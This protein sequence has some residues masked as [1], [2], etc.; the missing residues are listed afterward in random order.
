VVLMQTPRPMRGM[1][2]MLPGEVEIRRRALDAIR[3]TYR[4]HGFLEI[5][6]PIVETLEALEASGAGENEKLMFKLLKR[7]ERLEAALEG[8]EGELAD[9]GLRFDLTVP[10]ARFYA[11]NQ[12]KLPKPFY[13]MQIGPVFRAERPQKGRYRQFIQTDIDVLG[14][15]S[16]MAEIQLLIAATAALHK[17]GIEGF[18]IHLNDRRV[19]EAV[20]ESL[21]VAR[22]L[23]VPVMIALDKLDKVQPKAVVDE[24]EERGLPGEHATR[25]V[26]TLAELGD[27]ESDLDLAKLGIDRALAAPLELIQRHVSESVR[28]VEVVFDPLTVRGLGYYTSTV[29]ELVHPR[30]PGSLGGGGRY[31]DLVGRFGV[32]S[33]A[34]GISLGFERV[35]GK[36]KK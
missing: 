34:C 36:R 26:A 23:F 7:G 6:T 22:E 9:A 21:G 2:D 10:L 31:D 28:D 35:V 14:D 20:L 5:E 30:W 18:E 3:E 27:P 1:R 15:P 29:Y 19:L 25:V 16:R 33:P 32:E 8:E 17:L 4:R 11:I 13:A 24:L 12:S